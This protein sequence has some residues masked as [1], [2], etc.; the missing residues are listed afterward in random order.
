[1]PD[2]N[3]AGVVLG[4]GSTK[5]QIKKK[6]KIN[7]QLVELQSRLQVMNLDYDACA[8]STIKSYSFMHEAGT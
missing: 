8:D 4:S 2:L 5:P 3:A 6:D 7:E 1:M